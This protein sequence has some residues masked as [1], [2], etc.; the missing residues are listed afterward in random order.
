MPRKLVPYG[1]FLGLD[2]I[3][4]PDNMASRNLAWL[5]NAYVDHKGQIQAAPGVL[6]WI[7][8]TYPDA[9]W[10][11]RL[12]QKGEEADSGDVNGIADQTYKEVYGSFS[13]NGYQTE[14]RGV[15]IKQCYTAE[16]SSGGTNNV[17]NQF[18]LQVTQGSSVAYLKDGSLND[19]VYALT[20]AGTYTDAD[21]WHSEEVASSR[22]VAANNTTYKTSPMEIKAGDYVIIDSGRSGQFLGLDEAILK[23][24]PQKITEVGPWTNHYLKLELRNAAGSLVS[25][26]GGSSS[27][28]GNIDALGNVAPKIYRGFENPLGNTRYTHLLVKQDGG[29]NALRI[30]WGGTQSANVSY[31]S[32]NRQYMLWEGD[33]YGLGGASTSPY[34]GGDYNYRWIEGQDTKGDV[35]G[36]QRLW[37]YNA[38]DTNSTANNVHPYD[39]T[40]P[41]EFHNPTHV[42]FDNKHFFFMKTWD[43]WVYN[44]ATA[45]DTHRWQLAQNSTLGDTVTI[46]NA[47]PAVATKTAHGLS[48]G[49]AISFGT[50]GAL[51]TGVVDRTNLTIRYDVGEDRYKYPKSQVYYVTNVPDAD[52]FRFSAT[53]GGSD[54]NT[55]SAGS[56]THHLSYWSSLESFPRGGVAVTIQNRLVVAD[57]YGKETELHISTLSK[58]YDW[59]T[60]TS[61]G[62]TALATDGAIIDVRNQFSGE[63][64]I[65]GLGVLEGDKLVIFGENETLVYITDTDINRWQLATDFR[66]NIGVYGRNTIVNVGQDLFFASRFGLHS[67]RRALSGLTLESKTYSTPVQNLWEDIIKDCPPPRENIGNAN[68]LYQVSETQTDLSGDLGWGVF[69]STDCAFPYFYQTEPQ[70]YYDGDLGHYNIFFPVDQRRSAALRFTFTPHSSDRGFSS[71]AYNPAGN[72]NPRCGS[73]RVT[74]KVGQE[75]THSNNTRTHFVAYGTSNS[76]IGCSSWANLQDSWLGIA[77]PG[78]VPISFTATG[79]AARNAQRPGYMAVRTPYLW[80]G[81]PDTYKYYRRILL[82]AIQLQPEGATGDMRLTVHVY[83]QDNNLRFSKEVVPPTRIIGRDATELDAQVAPS[84]TQGIVSTFDKGTGDRPIEIPMSIRAKGVSIAITISNTNSNTSNNSV[85]H[86]QLDGGLIISDL[87]LIVDAK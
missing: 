86:T 37:D 70:A 12:S 11:Y 53:K 32:S 15:Y 85:E 27:T 61:D 87:G 48:I 30:Y 81:Q 56:G 50:D 64:K 45:A 68:P 13:T 6:G 75:L 49:D 44:G 78:Y 59:R 77:N 1:K 47:S 34:K 5:E 65:L 57:L 28:Y 40:T 66:I 71:W 22:A 46:N 3:A 83:D 42:S 4:T 31:A 19:G 82:R 20:N 10:T 41:I 29:D 72:D 18:T 80:Q 9:S 35:Y 26:T 16:A 38:M 69:V 43:P 58:S 7:R 74:Q 8:Q 36:H 54:I 76:L 21:L 84:A 23:T 24:V 55:S 60:N 62:S 79:I 63:D 39:E 2:T 14:G 52:T 17:G 25:P 67:I 73:Y 51:P 33:R